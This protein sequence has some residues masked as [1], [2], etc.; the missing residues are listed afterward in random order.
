[1]RAV[2]ETTH[3]LLLRPVTMRSR[4]GIARHRV[5]HAS[6]NL[7]DLRIAVISDLHVCRPWTPPA[8]I[9]RIVS[10]VN[11]LGPDLI[12]LP[13]DFIADRN[14]PAGRVPAAEIVALLEPL[15]A[16]LGVAAVLGNHDW[17]DCAL[18]RRT[19]CREN[20][21]RNAF[22]GSPIRL[23]T[24]EA[25]RVPHGDGFWLVGTDSQMVRARSG[26]AGFHDAEA[27]F[28]QVTDDA[29]AI[30]M[31]HEPDCFASDE[32]R[33]FLQISGHTHGGQA[34]LGGWRPLTPSRF[35]SR[36]AYGHIRDGDR[37]LVVSGG[38]GFSGVPIRL[39]Q[40]PEITL[41]TVA[42]QG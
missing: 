11:S 33:A 26:R 19:D 15:S 13:G 9:S 23:L 28:G 4:P 18:S 17:K 8:L 14:L 27:A 21:V 24:N 1:M 32:A 12:L 2:R 3:R 31:A 34:N 20:S 5:A 36:F 29:P 40:P 41:V 30:L 42:A 10:L 22:R 6:W 35:G 7:P 16:P 38:I 37:H 25:M 39:F